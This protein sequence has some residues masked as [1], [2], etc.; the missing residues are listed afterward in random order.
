MSLHLHSEILLQDIRYAC[1]GLRRSPLFSFTAITALALGIGAGTAVFSVVDRILFRS[2]PY[3]EAERLVSVGVTAPIVPQEFILGADYL[4]WRKRQTPFSSIT[5]WT[6]ETDCDLTEANPVRLTCAQVEANFLSTLGITPFAGRN[7]SPDEDLPKGPRAVILSYGLWKS[8]FAGDFHAIG[9]TLPLDGQ[10]AS[11]VGVLPPGFE[12][13]TLVHADLLVL[14]KLDE[15]V[16]RRP[17]TGRVLRSIA[18]LKPGLSPAQAASALQ[19]L[20]EESLQYVPPQFRKEVK[21]KIRALRDLQIQDARLASWI[22]LA[23]V[24]AVL[25]IACANVANLLLARAAIR[26]HELAIR[27]AIGAARLRLFR[28]TLTESLLLAV[29]GGGAGCLLA[30]VL[31]RALTAVAPEG[32]P[33]LQQ[34]GLDL[35]VLLFTLA[36]SLFCGIVFGVVP[37]L[38]MPSMTVGGSRTVGSRHYLLRHALVASQICVSLILL[39]GA[40]LLLRSL[41]NIQNQPLGLRTENVMAASVSLGANTYADPARQL[42]FFEELERR[43]RRVPGIAQ[44]GMSDS[45]PFGGFSH[46]TIYSV[47]DVQGRPRMPE[48]TGGMVTWRIVTPGY[49]NALGI[50]LLRGVGFREE[51]RDPDRNPVILSDSLARRLFPGENPVGKQIQPGRSGPWLTVAGV[52][53]NVKNQGLTERDDPEFYLVR[54]HAPDRRINR[55][56]AFVLRGAMDPGAMARWIRAEVNALDPTL[57]VSVE[58]LDQRVGKLAQRPRFNAL[59]LGLFASVGLLLSAIGLYGIMSFLVAERTREIGVRMALGATP[60]VVT[61]LILGHASRWCAAGAV[62]GAAGAWLATRVLQSMLFQVSAKDPWTLSAALALLLAV[63]LLA[64]W[65]PSRRAARIDPIAALRR[66]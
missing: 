62:L 49:F 20:F 56:S 36:V 21:L 50:P 30:A 6:G 28:Q 25:L 44:L 11:I 12:M 14:Q 65:I 5:T 1:R 19:P 27:V 10:S 17:N 32:I 57:P 66:D 34:A 48:G 4:E 52:A 8:R 2:L 37:A 7:F 22:L 58:T 39:A 61:K 43:L 35:R 31:L 45:L 24:A 54:K 47:I 42:A 53:G 59:L 64:A 41:W 60:A 55:T 63:G 26:Q 40:G 18:R 46:S 3:F 15:A 29:F 9:K 13:P 38:Q 23:A 33:R 16:Q 51:D